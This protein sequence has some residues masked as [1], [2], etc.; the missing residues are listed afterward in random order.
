MRASRRPRRVV[1]GAAALTD[2][3]LVAAFGLIPSL[4][5]A[6]WADE[7]SFGLFA[8]AFSVFLFALVIHTALVTEPM[9]V[10]APGRFR[11][12]F[13]PYLRTLAGL[14][15]LLSAGLG[16]ILLAAA[17]LLAW[18]GS[19]LGRPLAYLGVAVPLVLL[20]YFVRRAAYASFHVPLAA[21]ASALAAAA[22]VA[23]LVA[24]RGAI[25]SDVGVAFLALAAAGATT[26]LVFPAVLR[27]G[28]AEG[29]EAVARREV[30]RQH[31]RY[32]RWALG[33]SAVRWV[34][35]NV[36]YVYLPVA[37][38]FQAAA[39]LRALMN[40]VAPATRALAAMA[41][42]L[43]PYFVRARDG[44]G[45][46]QLV[47][48][49][50]ALVV[51]TVP[52]YW[53]ALGVFGEPLVRFLYDGKYADVAGQLWVLGAVPL[54]MGTG[55]VFQ[56]ALRAEERPRDIFQHQLVAI[57]L[58]LPVAIPLADVWNGAFSMA[59]LVG[60]NAAGLTAGYLRTR[61]RPEAPS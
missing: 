31:W 8:T 4:L 19:P 32:G 22:S 57:L 18:A 10:F 44:G 17:G 36:L 16:G 37:A 29:R 13:G 25:R 5:V 47:G 52:L 48:R 53:L 35:T 56:A 15:L 26:A 28:G 40:L 34:P 54:L 24:L 11:A 21:A 42:V 59:I 61:G 58:A 23:A 50:L 49:V 60:F 41:T 27:S 14:N 6:R 1:Q 33:A 30:V 2:Q 46:T 38:G 7:G 55:S 51:A 20:P 12:A 45:L 43:L 3:A 39:A 9:M